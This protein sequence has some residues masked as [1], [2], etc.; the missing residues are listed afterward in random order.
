MASPICVIYL[1]GKVGIN[2]QQ[3]KKKDCNFEAIDA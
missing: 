1:K 2:E 3:A